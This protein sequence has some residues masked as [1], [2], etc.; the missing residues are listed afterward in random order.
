MKNTLKKASLFV[1][2]LS[3]VVILFGCSNPLS[4]LG[5]K[6]KVGYDVTVNEVFT[7]GSYDGSELLVVNFDVDNKKDEGIQAYSIEYGASVTTADGTLLSTAY[8]GSNN[9]Y[10]INTDGQIPAKT[11]GKSQAAFDITNV[12]LGETIH[13]TVTGLA[14]K[15]TVSILDEDVEVASIQKKVSQSD[16]EFAITDKEITEDGDGNKLLILTCNFK[17]NSTE[18]ISC[19]SAVRMS[20]FQSG[21]ELDRGYLPYNHPLRKESDDDNDSFTEIKGGSEI[22]FKEV[23]NLN[24]ME[25][26]IEIKVNDWKTFDQVLIYEEDAKMADIPEHIYGSEYEFKYKTAIIGLDRWKE[27]IIVVLVGEFTNNSDEA[28]SFSNVA[29]IDVKQDGFTLS[30][31]YSLAGSNDWLRREVQ[32]GQTSLIYVGYEI[33]TKGDVEIKIT[34]R[35][36]YA[37][38]ELYSGRFSLQQLVQNTINAAEDD[39]SVLGSEIE[40]EDQVNL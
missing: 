10:Y 2:L 20:I 39:E 21:R 27:N 24:D 6:S 17:N 37:K 18:A 15:G 4:L 25:G 34:D 29:D 31:S 7:C 16:F 13:I 3:V 14:K 23:Y 26:D 19:G 30:K 8:M 1:S 35:W 36:H 12:D 11:Q 28:T 40:S 22:T 9:P 5:G 33:K 38:A 32:P